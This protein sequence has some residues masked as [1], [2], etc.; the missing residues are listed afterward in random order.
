VEMPGRAR[1]PVA[2]LHRQTL[3]VPRLSL[4]PVAPHRAQQQPCHA[5]AC[6][7]EAMAPDP[8]PLAHAVRRC[9]QSQAEGLVDMS[10]RA[11]SRLVHLHSH[12]VRVQ[13]LRLPDVRRQNRR[14]IEQLRRTL[15]RAGAAM[16]PY[17][18]RPAPPDRHRP[19]IEHACLVEMPPGRR[20]RVARLFSAAAQPPAVPILYRPT[21]VPI[22]VP[23]RPIPAPRPR[24]A[25]VAQRR[26]HAARRSS[27]RE[28]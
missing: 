16:A 4:L 8:K 12:P 18:E 19:R 13:L 26:A 22:G 25:P 7:G 15:S 14:A 24:V 21:H 11:R 5:P 27:H 10:R 6:A 2:R 20:A 9:A 3:R 17:P 1:P 28:P 23:G